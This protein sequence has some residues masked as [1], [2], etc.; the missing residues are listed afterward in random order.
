MDWKLIT[1]KSWSPSGFLPAA[2]CLLIETGDTSRLEKGRDLILPARRKKL[3]HAALGDFDAFLRQ[4][5]PEIPEE[6]LVLLIVSAYP[7]REASTQGDTLTPVLAVGPGF[8]P[9]LLYSP[10]TRQPG[11]AASLIHNLL[12]AAVGLKTPI[13]FRASS[14]LSPLLILL[15]ICRR[16]MPYYQGDKDCP[17]LKGFVVSKLF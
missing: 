6:D 15:A 3:L 2:D 4:L 7:S 17:I 8:A 10:S 13:V 16:P 5:R 9:G 11:S 14:P 1:T 12:L